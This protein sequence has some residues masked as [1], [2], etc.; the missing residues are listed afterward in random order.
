MRKLLISL[1]DLFKWIMELPKW[2][3]V[4]VAS[5]TIVAALS[6]FLSSIEEWLMPFVIKPPVLQAPFDVSRH[7]RPGGFMGDGEKCANCIEINDAYSG[8]ARPGSGHAFS[9]R[10][11][12]S[13][14]A[15]K[16]FAGIYRSWPDHNW[17][18][19]P[20]WRVT[21]ATRV[22][23]WA[24]GD[25]GGEIVEFKAGGIAKG[26]KRPF[27]DTFEASLGKVVLTKEW[28]H[29]DI[30]LGSCSLKDVIGAFAWT[31]AANWNPKPTVFYLDDIRYE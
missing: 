25:K 13:Q 17:G 28:Q 3:K 27:S 24:A 1:A 11:S 9:V 6:P 31:A 30:D 8:K 23:F 22:S 12:Y 18:E 14:T 15:E 4:I 10:V 2:G 20:G 7:Y 5:G 29:F 26:D 16:K 21:G 19:H